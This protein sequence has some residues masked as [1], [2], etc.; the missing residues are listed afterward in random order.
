MSGDKWR[1]HGTCVL[2]GAKVTRNLVLSWW[3]VTPLLSAS[4]NVF[5]GLLMKCIQVSSRV[6]IQETFALLITEGSL[7]CPPQI[8]HKLPWDPFSL[9]SL[10]CWLVRQIFLKQFSLIL[11]RQ[12]NSFF[13]M[14]NYLLNKM[15]AL[16]LIGIH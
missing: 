1:C 15:C 4:T 7:K 3:I 8:V 10:G 9:E 13:N 12:A 14:P 5:S 11:D 16:Q 2:I 6:K